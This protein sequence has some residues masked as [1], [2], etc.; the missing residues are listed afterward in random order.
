M[1]LTT[2]YWII[3]VALVVAICVMAAALVTFVTTS[4]ETIQRISA[5]RSR[6]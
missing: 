4:Y 3:T 2:V 1:D 5:N 6:N